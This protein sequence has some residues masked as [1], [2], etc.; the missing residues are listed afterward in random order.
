MMTSIAEQ[1]ANAR[2]AAGMTQEDLA[3]ALH[4][5][6]SA[7]S[8]WERG[9][10]EPDLDTLRQLAQMLKCS[11]S[12]ADA[13]T[14][15]DQPAAKPAEDAETAAEQTLTRQPSK[16]SRKKGLII[17]IAALVVALSVCTVLFIVPA[18]QNRAAEAKLPPAVKVAAEDLFLQLPDPLTPDWF[19]AGNVRAEG[20]PWLELTTHITCDTADFSEPYWAYGAAFREVTGH[21]FALDYANYYLFW[22]QGDTTQ[23]ELIYTA[24]GDE[25]LVDDNI[26]NYWEYNCGLPVQDLIGAGYQVVG[27]DQAGHPM[28][29]RTYIDFTTAPRE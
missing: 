17:G 24:S 10:T 21:P 6:R 13:V 7:V 12:P 5:T 20:E 27:H 4:V 19:Q 8:S 2:K 18:I 22:V 26:T 29:F 16:V 25:L 9:R 1:I 28:T 23:G 14:A 11:F 3:S 15:A